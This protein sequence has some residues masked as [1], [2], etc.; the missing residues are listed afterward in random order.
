V[1]A[2]MSRRWSALAVAG[3]AVAAVAVGQLAAA[4]PAHASAAQQVIS[5]S[6]SFKDDF[7]D[8]A[9]LSRY[10][11]YRHSNAV[12]LWQRILQTEHLYSGAI[13]CDFGPATEAATKAYQSKYK[14]GVDGVVGPQ[15]WS[16]AD[17]YLDDGGPDSSYPGN[18]MV[19]YQAP[20]LLTG[21]V[22]DRATGNGYYSVRLPDGVWVTAWD[23]QASPLC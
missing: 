10:G 7:G 3:V 23:N 17:N 5:G 8:E 4:A 2:N 15:T 22:A 16:W 1:F 9:T 11:Q 14:L 20:N 6:G 19:L 21:W 13:D 12:A 18:E